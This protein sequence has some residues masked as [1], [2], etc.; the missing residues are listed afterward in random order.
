MFLVN[1]LC[2]LCFFHFDWLYTFKFKVT[3][4]HVSVNFK[5]IV[6]LCGIL[7]S[8]GTIIKDVQHVNKI[9][10]R[11]IINVIFTG[12]TDF[13]FIVTFTQLLF[14]DTFRVIIRDSLCLGGRLWILHMDVW[15]LVSVYL[16]TNISITE[17]IWKFKIISGFV[18]C[19]NFSF[20]C[21]LEILLLLHIITSRYIE[22]SLC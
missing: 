15:K 7:R 5:L 20:L 21:S 18:K 12:A 9:I 6:H 10:Q 13:L 17:S 11:Q 1:F 4:Q 14:V 19:V 3:I 22:W 16:F 2:A 8:N